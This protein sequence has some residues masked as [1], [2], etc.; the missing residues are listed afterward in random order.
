MELQFNKEGSFYVAEATVNNDYSL[1]VERETEGF[2]YME[3]RATADGK[4]GNCLLPSTISSGYWLTLDNTFAHG[5]YPMTVRFK[6]ASP[7]TKAELQEV[8]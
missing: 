1:H 8:Q 6:S 2:F 7:V 5:F 4:F 3:Q